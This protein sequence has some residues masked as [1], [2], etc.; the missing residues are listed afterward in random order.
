VQILFGFLLSLALHPA[1]RELHGFD[2]AVYTVA[3]RG[4]ALA[5]MLLIASVSFHRIVFR[6]RQK[7]HRLSVW[8]CSCPRS[9]APSG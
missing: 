3:L 2:L 5:T 4:A 1:V 7:P 9:A 8:R 6:R